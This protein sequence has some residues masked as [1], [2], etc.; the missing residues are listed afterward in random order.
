MSIFRSVYPGQ[1]LLALFY[2]GLELG[3]QDKNHVDL[4]VLKLKIPQPV[5]HSSY[6]RIQAIF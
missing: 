2:I 6:E 3:S 1:F 4:S 5:T